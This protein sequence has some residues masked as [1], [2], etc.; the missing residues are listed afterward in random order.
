M[1]EKLILTPLEKAVASLEDGLQQPK[2][3]YNRDMVIQRFEYTYELSWK[4]LKRYLQM[5]QGVEESMLRN[6]FREAGKAGLVDSVE[7]WF[8]Y[9]EARNLTS[10]T[11]NE[12]AAEETYEAAKKFL[13]DVKFTLNKLKEGV[14]HAGS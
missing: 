3:V 9:Q 5:Y 13:T 4:M 1:K 14:E 8:Y 6:I 7:T 12:D 11:Y 2:T 10:H